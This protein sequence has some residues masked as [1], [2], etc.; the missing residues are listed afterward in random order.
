MIVGEHVGSPL[1][2]QCRGEPACS[3]RLNY[4]ERHQSAKLKMYTFAKLLSEHQRNNNST[5]EQLASDVGVKRQTIMRWKTGESLPSKREHILKLANA[6]RLKP[7]RRDELLYA[8]QKKPENPDF[9]SPPLPPKPLSNEPL[10]IPVIARPIHHPR[11]FFGRYA[12][13]NRIFQAW[14]QSI[15]QHPKRCGKTSLLNYVKSIHYL[16]QSVLRDG[17]RQDWLEP[18]FD[19]VLIDFDDVRTHKPD[20][21]LRLIL[22]TLNI[23]APDE[24]HDFAK[25]TEIFENNLDRATVLLIDQ[26]EKGLQL[27]A[28]DQPFWGNLRYLGN[29]C[30]GKLGF[31]VTSRQSIDKLIKT[32][33]QLGKP[34]PFFNIF[35]QIELGP[36]T[37]QEARELL[38]YVSL[39]QDDAEWIL[40]KSHYWP[41]L[42]Q[43][44]C[45][46]RLDS[47]NDWKKVGLETIEKDYK[48]LL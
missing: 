18:L 2:R 13:L 45:Q 4:C 33:H 16:E 39:S 43:V 31:C 47:E 32:A 6:L 1:R 17:Q 35:G 12:Q 5:Y 48:Y 26:I 40:E 37:E 27:P 42:L 30:N 7:R 28:L 41:V 9:K 36:L 29:H 24:H 21:F 46:I 25:L 15:L 38:Q 10:I 34:S 22:E 11:Q 23:P 19:W 14:N 20:S 44:L 3:P 8:A